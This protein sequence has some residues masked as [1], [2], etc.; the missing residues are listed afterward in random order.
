MRERQFNSADFIVT[1]NGEY[2]GIYID[3]AVTV[4]DVKKK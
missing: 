4:D 1:I 3:S 2:V